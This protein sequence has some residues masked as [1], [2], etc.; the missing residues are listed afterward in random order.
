MICP[1]CGQPLGSY[2]TDP[3]L[4]DAQKHAIM[5]RE[6]K[7]ISAMIPAIFDRSA[8]AK[9]LGSLGGSVKGKSKARAV[10]YRKLAKL[11]HAKRRANNKAQNLSQS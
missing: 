10:D 6:A 7:V 9:A 4:S 5:L 11:S 8:A 3:C 2:V 1:D